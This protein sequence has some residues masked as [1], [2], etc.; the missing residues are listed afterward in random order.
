MAH[1]EPGWVLLEYEYDPG[2]LRARYELPDGRI[3]FE[4]FTVPSR[5]LPVLIA[6]LLVHADQNERSD[7]LR[8]EVAANDRLVAARNAAMP[9]PDWLPAAMREGETLW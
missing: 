9:V 3:K 6:A 2:L 4:T 8:A 5:T 7:I 1:P